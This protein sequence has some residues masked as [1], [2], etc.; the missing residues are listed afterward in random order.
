MVLFGDVPM[1]VFGASFAV[2]VPC[3]LAVPARGRLCAH[4]QRNWLLFRFVF[5]TLMSRVLTFRSEQASN[6]YRR[7]TKDAFSFGVT[8]NPICIMSSLMSFIYSG[9]TRSTLHTMHPSNTFQHSKPFIAN[10]Y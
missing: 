9:I 2:S 5:V 4:Q 10:K 3:H 6:K 8:S 7:G 1:F